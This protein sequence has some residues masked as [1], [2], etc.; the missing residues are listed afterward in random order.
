MLSFRHNMRC[1]G[2]KLASRGLGIALSFTAILNPEA[3]ERGIAIPS[4]CV[5]AVLPS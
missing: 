3:I 4:F 2:N 5:L 1:L